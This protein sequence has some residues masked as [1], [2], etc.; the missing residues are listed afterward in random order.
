[1]RKA[2]S[3][4]V[5]VMEDREFLEVLVKMPIGHSWREDAIMFAKE[6]S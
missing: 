6:K 5:V 3:G 4:A 2:P 1:M